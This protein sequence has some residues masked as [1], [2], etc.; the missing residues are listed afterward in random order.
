MTQKIFLSN[1]LKKNKN[2][3][4]IGSLGTI[5]YDLK[6]IPHKNKI[7]IA[8]AMG[9]VMGVALGYALSSK[10]KVICIIGDG[11]FIMKQGSVNTI[12]HYRPKNLKVYIMVNGIYAST[13]G[14]EISNIF[15]R[16]PKSHFKLCRVD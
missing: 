13:G 9:C 8:G 3:I 1:L 15:T 14:Q 2:A 5:S 11:A 16:S 10:K 6:Q 12:M 4:I 7:L